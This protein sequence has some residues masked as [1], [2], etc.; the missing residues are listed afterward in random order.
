M[1]LSVKE[2]LD[3]LQSENTKKTY[4]IGLNK[5]SGWYGK[6]SEECL[7]Q[8]KEDLTQRQGENFIDYK[9]RASL[10]E[11]IIEKFY[12]HQIS[13]G[14]KKNTA[15]CHTLGIRS[16]FDYYKMTVKMRNGTI[17]M[18]KT[19]RRFPL[20]IEHVRK[21]YQ[22][23][24]L[25]ERV[26]LCMATDLGLRINDFLGIKKGDLPLLD[27]EAPIS[28]D[29]MT[30]KED[31]VAQGFL[32]HE[33]VEVL[34]L[35]LPTLKENLYL[36]PSWN[37]SPNPVSESWL[38]TILKKLCEKA[39][40]DTNAKHFTFSCFRKMFLST[41]IDSGVGLTAGKLMC[42]KT[43]PK[44]DA[45]YLTTVQLRKRYIKLKRLLI[46]AS[47]PK[48]EVQKIEELTK[49]VNSLQEDVSNQKTINY[50]VS[51]S[52]SELTETVEKLESQ[53]TEINTKLEPY[54]IYQGIFKNDKEME[55][56]AKSLL[57]TSELDKRR[58][59]G[60]GNEEAW[61]EL[62]KAGII[63]ENEIPIKRGEDLSYPIT[64]I[65]GKM[66]LNDIA[67]RRKAAKKQESG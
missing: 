14:L 7:K 55:Q 39:G 58:E 13:V 28:F 30:K 57:L 42:G 21:M 11:K 25:R 67:R 23:A 59:L 20:R 16:L 47:E 1:D 45:T 34:N 5:F 33:T 24:D 18:V 37:G 51:K 38:G 48:V 3:S 43:V 31:V 17:K 22:V 15:R 10:F 27:Q 40:I 36:F 52:N 8:R 6:T 49:A 9:N 56:F 44:A 65:L 19:T 2:F 46:I 54:D 60:M 62:K 29:V 4:R 63:T 26:I 66:L 35:Y 64:G 53:I 50:V 61:E 32:S 12:K 41:S